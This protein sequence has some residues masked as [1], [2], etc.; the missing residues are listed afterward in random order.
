[1]LNSVTGSR[2]APGDGPQGHGWVPGWEERSQE[3]V[4]PGRN[5]KVLFNVNRITA[6]IL[7]DFSGSLISFTNSFHFILIYIT[8][9]ESPLPSR[10]REINLE[11]INNANELDLETATGRGS[12]HWPGRLLHS[13][14]R[15]PGTQCRQS[16]KWACFSVSLQRGCP[17]PSPP[18]A[19]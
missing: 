15:V 5:G 18:H 16:G 13:S 1:M 2:T 11:R 4:L 19:N 3:G 9:L 17:W 14:L 10:Q 8:L 6:A 7:T 12:Q